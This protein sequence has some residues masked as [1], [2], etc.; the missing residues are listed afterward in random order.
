MDNQEEWTGP[1]P[2][3]TCL[4]AAVEV[5]DQLTLILGLHVGG[6]LY[7]PPRS[8]ENPATNAQMVDIGV[9]TEVQ[10]AEAL[11]FEAALSSS[12]ALLRQRQRCTS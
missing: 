9:A 8:I 10:G 6:G 12:A 11:T 3:V 2:C 1:L 5:P 4:A 7:P